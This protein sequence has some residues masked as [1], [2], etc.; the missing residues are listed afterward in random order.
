MPKKWTVWAL[1]G[2]I[3]FTTLVTGCSSVGTDTGGTD[4]QQANDKPMLPIP[5]GSVTLRYATYDNLYEP[6]SYTQNL[7]V[8]QE[9]EKRTGVKIKWEVAVADQYKQAIQVKLAA[10]SDLPDIFS[11]PD[12]DPVKLAGNGLLM[13]LDD[14]IKKY[15][16]NIEKFLKENP[17]L[18]SLMKSSDG[19]MYALPNIVKGYAQTDPY[20]L[21]IRK[22]WLD[23]Y[24]LSEPKTLDDWYIALKTFQEKDAN[25]NGIKD[26]VFLPNFTLRGLYPFGSAL[27]LHL[28]FSAGFFPD[29]KGKVQYEFLD[30]R[31]KQLVTWLNKL[32][33]EGLINKS[34]MT[35]TRNDILAK[36]TKNIAGASIRS[37]NNVNRY[38]SL[39]KEA[40]LA[41]V[42]WTMTL[43]PSGPGYKGNYE[44][45]G[46]FDGWHGISKDSKNPEVAIQWLDYIYASEEGN[47]IL[48]FG[49][50]GKSY[51]IVNGEPALSDW[52]T[53]N[54]DGLSLDIALRSIGAMPT[55]VWLTNDKG[56]TSKLP[57]AQI[58][59]SP[60]AD[61]AK[62]VEPYLTDANPFAMPSISEMEQI[63][64]LQ[65][66][67][68]TYVDEMMAKFI[69]G[70]EPI[71]WD[72]FKSTLKSMGIDQI[73][74]VKQKQYDRFKQK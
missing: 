5:N 15:A 29:D 14:L 72:K 11:L 49:I 73:I 40:G 10:A 28:F 41:S 52:V 65:T 39:Q 4:K 74:A 2:A 32:Y 17:D 31:M 22:D 63:G 18:H 38:N 19:K 59:V 44:R 60:V 68:N 56:F 33:A 7:P 67:I 23:K 51:S 16:P 24:G 37:L 36:V 20:G 58:K 13:P 48:S 54:P 21:F 42:N 50:E 27:G 62:K 61:L 43:P 1:C 55:T 71:N 35:D 66:D 45:Y 25:G 53:K 34:F 70:Q 47:R 30:D 69:T 12:P 57:Q 26:E 3:S 64:S 9:I 46:P 6:A 8:W